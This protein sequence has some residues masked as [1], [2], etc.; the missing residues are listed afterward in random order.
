MIPS[1]ALTI[2]RLNLS[3]LSLFYSSLV[4]QTPGISHRL[5][6]TAAVDFL[7]GRYRNPICGSNAAR[8]TMLLTGRAALMNNAAWP[9]E[10]RQCVSGLGRPTIALLLFVGVLIGGTPYVP[11]SFRWGYVGLI[12]AVTQL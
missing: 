6:P 9:L 3:S 2:R 4:L 1:D 10:L 8:Y 7:M 5:L 12:F 11:T